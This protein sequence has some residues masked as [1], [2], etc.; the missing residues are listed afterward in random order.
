MGRLDSPPRRWSLA[1]SLPLLAGNSAVG[2]N[3]AMAGP[4]ETTDPPRQK[5]LRNYLSEWDLT[6]EEVNEIIAENPPVLS[7][8]SGFVAEYKFRKLWLRDPRLS[9]VVRPRA[10]D[11]KSKGDFAFRYHGTSFTLEVKSLDVPKVRHDASGF[12]GTFQ[13]NASDSRPVQFP[14][15]KSLTT[16]CLLVGEFDVLAVSLFAF[17]RSWRFAF[18]ENGDLPRSTWAKYKPWQRRYLLKSSME[19]TW[20]LSPPY[21]EDLF[22]VLDSVLRKRAL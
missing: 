1:I 16:N 5:P 9:E 8:L 14:N 3:P 17:E 10:H 11:R 13:C 19:I 15:G 2:Q 12:R 21:H 18:A 20:P 22:G 6:P 4:D 7:T